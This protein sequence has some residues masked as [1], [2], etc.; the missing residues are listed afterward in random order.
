MKKRGNQPLPPERELPTEGFVRL[1]VVLRVMGISKTS[2][3]E[4]IKK[5]KFPK[6]AKF[7]S[8]TAGWHVDDLR[9][10]I[11]KLKDEAGNETRQGQAVSHAQ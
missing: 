5:G 8:R 6:P 11:A 2:W 1:P 4:G 7:T 9:A 10:L 3:W